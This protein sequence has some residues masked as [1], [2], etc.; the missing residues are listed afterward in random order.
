[1][2]LCGRRRSTPPRFPVLTDRDCDDVQSSRCPEL[3]IVENNEKRPQVRGRF[4]FCVYWQVSYLFT[5]YS[6]IGAGRLSFW[7]DGPAL[8]SLCSP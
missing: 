1:M 5:R 6:I 3:G 4:V 8:P 2:E 7:F